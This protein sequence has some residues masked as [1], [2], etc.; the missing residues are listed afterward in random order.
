MHLS[1][2]VLFL[3]II[4]G[5]LL[6]VLSFIWALRVFKLKPK[7]EVRKKLLGF[8][9]AFILLESAATVFG[10]SNAFAGIVSV[11]GFVAGLFLWAYL[12]QRLK[13]RGYTHG[14]AVGSYLFANF[15]A[16]M[17]S[18]VL[19]LLMLASV[20][21]A[22]VIEGPTMEPTLHP[23]DHVLVLKYARHP[24]ENEVIVYRTL[25]GKKALGRVRAVTGQSIIMPSDDVLVDGKP[26]TG[27]SFKL[28][29]DQYYVTVDNPSTPISRIIDAKAIVGTVGPKL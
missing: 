13:V 6:T 14:R 28:Q 21:Q 29:E 12:L 19:A 16:S 23:G 11:L 22:F 25:E 10:H 26:V 5:T 1:I 17:A 9:T 3:L 27:K 4:F 15:I 20:A 24:S 7:P 8:V 18:I 2:T